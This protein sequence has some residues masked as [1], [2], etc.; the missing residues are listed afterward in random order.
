MITTMNHTMAAMAR[1]IYS[2]GNAPKR[3]HANTAS[4]PNA[5]RRKTAN[6]CHGEPRYEASG[7]ESADAADCSALPQVTRALQ[8]RKAQATSGTPQQAF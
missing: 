1:N 4:P 7:D 2:M 5:K 8:H 6:D 3:L